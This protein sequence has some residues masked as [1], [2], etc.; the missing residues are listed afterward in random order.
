MSGMGRGPE[1]RPVCRRRPWGQA[2]RQCWSHDTIA[3]LAPSAVQFERQAVLL[4]PVA[5]GS[6]ATSPES[7]KPTAL[8]RRHF[9]IE[10]YT[11]LSVTLYFCVHTPARSR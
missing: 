4:P 2:S 10:S 5:G 9:F 8:V 6:A 11:G 3:V 1:R 7:K